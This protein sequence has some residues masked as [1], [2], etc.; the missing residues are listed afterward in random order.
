MYASQGFAE[1]QNFASEPYNSNT[2]EGEYAE[3]QTLVIDGGHANGVSALHFDNR[4]EL[5]WTGLDTGHTTSFFSSAFTK[6]TSFQVSI[7]FAFNNQLHSLGPWSQ[8]ARERH[9]VRWRRSLN[10]RPK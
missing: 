6:Y 4:E 9:P 8:S 7:N 5:L 1:Y 3:L 2:A 10:S